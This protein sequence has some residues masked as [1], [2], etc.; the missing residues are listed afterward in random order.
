MNLRL[1]WMV[2]IA[3]TE[4]VHEQQTNL[5]MSGTSYES[6][7]PTSQSYDDRNFLPVNPLDSNHHYSRDHD[8]TA[9]QLVYDSFT[10]FH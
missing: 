9:L 4:S 5:M 3:E 2:Q 8:H 6:I 1:M 7:N 10:V